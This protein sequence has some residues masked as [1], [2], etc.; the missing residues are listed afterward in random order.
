MLEWL[1]EQDIIQK[2][3]IDKVELANIANP[4]RLRY[5]VASIVSANGQV[6]S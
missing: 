3:M 6:L 1:S 2:K 4:F 5:T